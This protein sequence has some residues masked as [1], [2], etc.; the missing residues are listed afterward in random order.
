MKKY[1][2]LLLSLV[3]FSCSTEDDFVENQE[4]LISKSEVEA[5]SPNPVSLVKSWTSYG[6]YRG[7]TSYTLKFTV[8]VADLAFDKQVSI[9]HEKLDGSWEEIP[10]SYSFDIDN[11]NE[12]WTGQKSLG[13]YGASQVYADEFVVKYDVNGTTYWDNNNGANY[14]M[15]VRDG[16]FFADPNANVSVDTDFDSISYI[17]YYDKN[18]MTVTVDVRNLAPNKEVGVLYTTDGWQT[19]NY[20]TLNYRRYWSNGPFFYIQSPNQFDIERWSGSVQVDKSANTV[21]YVVVYKVNG[22]EYWD[23]NYGKNHVVSK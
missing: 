13:G 18:S 23:N 3:I 17:P 8:K 9:Y 4:S 16:Y 7:Y 11:Q 19:Q 10:L 1:I 22:Q 12:I 14:T 2:Y 5:T 21:E 6:S 15:S 20:F